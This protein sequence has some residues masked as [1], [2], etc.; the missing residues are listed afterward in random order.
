MALSATLKGPFNDFATS[1]AISTTDFTGAARFT[2]SGV[3]PL[4]V[5]FLNFVGLP[6]GVKTIPNPLEIETGFTV[7]LGMS[8]TVGRMNRG[9]T[10]PFSGP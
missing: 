5:N 1:S 2:P 7:G 6:A 3:G 9:F 4:S 8:S 10:G